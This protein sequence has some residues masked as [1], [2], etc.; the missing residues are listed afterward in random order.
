LHPFATL[1]RKK[2]QKIRP[3]NYELVGLFSAPIKY[4]QTF[5]HRPLFEAHVAQKPPDAAAEAKRQDALLNA[6]YFME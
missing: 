6:W 2:N 1:D 4:S 3:Y 5:G